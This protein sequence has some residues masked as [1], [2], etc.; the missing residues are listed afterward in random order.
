MKK[1]LT[2]LLIAASIAAQAA[3]VDWGIT[4]IRKTYL[5]DSTDNKGDFTAYLV[6]ASDVATITA[7]TEDKDFDTLLNQYKLDKVDLTGGT[8]KV[9]DRTATASDDVLKARSAGGSEYTFQLIL[10]DS[11][12][13]YSLSSTASAYAYDPSNDDATSLLFGNTDIGAA[14]QAGGTTWNEKPT[15][16]GGGQGGGETPGVPEPATG[17]LALAGVALLFKRRRA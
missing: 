6:L 3:S 17:A 12:G 2:F 15:Y 1:T 14:A 8:Y 11:K 10:V 13:K 16:G 9:D 5:Y 4:S 7:P